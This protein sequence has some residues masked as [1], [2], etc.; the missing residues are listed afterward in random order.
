MNFTFLKDKF[1]QSLTY[2]GLQFVYEIMKIELNTMINMVIFL[3]ILKK[4]CVV[5]LSFFSKNNISL[6]S[7]IHY[8]REHH[9][10]LT[11]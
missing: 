6:L 3:R 5:F 8:N 2:S 11:L 7:K 10:P 9:S 1:L 4:Y